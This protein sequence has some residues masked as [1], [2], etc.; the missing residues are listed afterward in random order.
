MKTAEQRKETLNLPT[1]R[2]DEFTRSRRSEALD[3]DQLWSQTVSTRKGQIPPEDKTWWWAG[4]Q[5]ADQL[6][7]EMGH[8]PPVLKRTCSELVSASP[9]T[10]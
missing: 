2:G 8:G 10:W 3:G 6:K 7:R 4:V 5:A 1:Q 9:R